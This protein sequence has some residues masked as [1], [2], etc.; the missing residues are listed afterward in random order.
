MLIDFLNKIYGN[1]RTHLSIH[2]L[3]PSGNLTDI[4]LHSG[5]T[6]W[7]ITEVLR[8]VNLYSTLVDQSHDECM[9]VCVCVLCAI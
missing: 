2:L 9:R 4:I 5:G 3:K 6:A 8:W 7:N 1:V